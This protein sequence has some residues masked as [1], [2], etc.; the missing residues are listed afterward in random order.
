MYGMRGRL[1]LTTILLI[2]EGVVILI[3]PF[4]DN[5]VGA[6]VTMCIFSI[7][8]QAAEG[9]IFGMY[10]YNSWRLRIIP[11][12]T[13]VLGVVPYVTKLYSGSVSGWVG[14]GGN[15][16][17]VVFGFGFRSLSYES[18]F[19]MMGC[20][21]VASSAL[22]A[23]INIPLYAGLLWGADNHTVIKARERFLERKAREQE[24]RERIA[25]GQ[26]ITEILEQQEQERREQ[27]VERPLFENDPATAGV[28]TP[29][30]TTSQ[31]TS[32]SIPGPA[33]SQ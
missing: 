9:A 14:A 31:P 33:A 22:S 15:V 10:S 27:H 30:S 11:S 7:F 23:M 12:L 25:S 13:L 1:W 18:A 19:V 26:E 20:L 32:L 28:T 8:T 2:L 29:L 6:V 17:S 5:L 3:F 16:G 24:I 4:V 21:V